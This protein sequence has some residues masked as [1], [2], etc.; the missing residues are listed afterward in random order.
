M[1]HDDDDIFERG[2]IHYHGEEPLS[3]WEWA[4]LILMGISF[5][6]VFGALAILV[7]DFARN[8]FL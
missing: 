4:V 3:G 5:V 8:N 7:H 2:Y 1:Q 6:V